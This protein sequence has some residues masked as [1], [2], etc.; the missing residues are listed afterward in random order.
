MYYIIHTI[1]RKS[2]LSGPKCKMEGRGA[3]IVVIYVSLFL[4]VKKSTLKTSVFCT[5][6][7]TGKVTRSVSSFYEG[8]RRG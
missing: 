1:F 6:I 7:V 2:R 8:R 5:I 3:L 4:F